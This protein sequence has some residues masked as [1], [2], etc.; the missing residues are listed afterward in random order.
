[1]TGDEGVDATEDDFSTAGFCSLE[2]DID[3]RRRTSDKDKKDRRH[4]EITE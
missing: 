4:L 3:T 1:M 2:Q